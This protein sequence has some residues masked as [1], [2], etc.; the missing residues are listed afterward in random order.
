METKTTI[1]YNLTFFP[2]YVVVEAVKGA[3]VDGRIASDVLKIIYDHYKG[4]NF[5]V[6]SHRKNDYKIDIDVY[7]LKLVKRL[8]GIAVVSSDITAKERAMEEQL[9]FNQ[10]FAFF[11]NLDDAKDWAQNFF[12]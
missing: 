3:V 9:A 7:S 5:T 10:S 11:E 1:A 6:V 2:D 12:R 8:K 4:R